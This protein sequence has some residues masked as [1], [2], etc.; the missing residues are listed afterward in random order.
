MSNYDTLEEFI[1]Y[2]TKNEWK[3]YI[4]SYLM[5][6]WEDSLILREFFENLKSEF[7]NVLLR[8]VSQED[9]PLLLGGIIPVED[10]VYKRNSLAKFYSRFFGLKISDFQ[11]WVLGAGLTGV[12]PKVIVD[13]TA[14][15]RFVSESFKWADRAMRYQ[16]LVEYTEPNVDYATFKKDPNKL[17]DLISDFYQCILNISVNYN[18]Y[19]F[20][21][22]SLNQITYKFMKEAYPRIDQIMDM[23]QMDFGLTRL[24]WRIPFSEDSSFY[25]DYTIYCWPEYNAQ[26]DRGGWCDPSHSQGRSFGGS[27]CALNETIWKYLAKGYAPTELEK[28][29]L[30]YFTIFPNLKEEYVGRVKDRLAGRIYSHIYYRGITAAENRSELGET[31]MTIM[32]MIDEVSPYLF[33][34]LAKI[35]YVGDDYLQIS[36]I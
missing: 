13:E 31:N 17:K 11:S 28:I 15:T 23:L 1:D 25:K 3:N 10:Q 32:Q 12:D 7:Q 21:L 34:G 14:F 24:K 5:P 9:L 27:I 4:K 22:W 6:L 8:D 18:Y 30:D 16:T 19:T 33:T 36:Q 29:I 35:V 20:F 2:T 26:S